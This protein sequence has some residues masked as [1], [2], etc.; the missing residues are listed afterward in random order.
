MILYKNVDIC[1]LESILEKG[2]LSLDESG[3]NNWDVGRRAGNATDCVYLFQPIDGR[4]NS[5]TNYGVALLEIDVDDAQKSE[6]CENDAHAKDYIEYTT[7]AVDPGK[8]NRIIIPEIFKER[9]DLSG[10]AERMV[11]WC[12]FSAEIYGDNGMETASD[13]I[14][15]MF[16]KTAGIN[17]SVLDDLFF[18][19]INEKRHVIDVYNVNYVF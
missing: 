15:E 5:F 14:V 16:A 3:N 8:I 19:G 6:F 2:I 10:K 9:L 17:S 11:E 4:Q 13:E 7:G 18:R 12:G 1:D